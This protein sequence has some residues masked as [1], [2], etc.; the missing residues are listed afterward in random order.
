VLPLVGWAITGD[1]EAYR[2]L[3]DSI[4]QFRSLAEFCALMREV[5]FATVEGEDLFPSGVASLVVAS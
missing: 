3:P 2:Y 4:A 1:R 5:G